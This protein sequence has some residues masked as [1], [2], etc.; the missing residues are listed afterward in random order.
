ME[1]SRGF[2]CS[3]KADSFCAF[4]NVDTSALFGMSLVSRLPYPQ[5]VLKDSDSGRIVQSK[6]QSLTQHEPGQKT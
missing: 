6:K 5:R 4:A 3:N 2:G 1:E